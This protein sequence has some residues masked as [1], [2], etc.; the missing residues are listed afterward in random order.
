M[1]RPFILF[2]LAAIAIG[3]CTA[4][5]ATAPKMG[6]IFPGKTLGPVRLTSQAFSSVTGVTVPL[7]S[8]AYS[9]V[10]YRL[11]LTT[12]SGGVQIQVAMTGLTASYRSNQLY[13]ESPAWAVAP[14]DVAAT[15]YWASGT[16]V[17]GTNVTGEIDF[18]NGFA[19]QFFC[20]ESITQGSI[21]QSSFTGY[22]TDTTNVVTAVVFSWGVV[23][24]T[25][26]LEV[27][28]WP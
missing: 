4:K 2:A 10:R 26:F 8:G 24:A 15:S 13:Q 7:A 23:T 16:T 28:G 17:A 20:R 9:R 21:S 11:N 1:K 6:L 18:R 5:T 25:G 22:N 12:V 19:R 14:F 3:G 27:W